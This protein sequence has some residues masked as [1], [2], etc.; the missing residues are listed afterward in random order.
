MENVPQISVDANDD[1]TTE[2]ASSIETTQSHTY[3]TQSNIVVPLQSRD[4]SFT[5]S[6]LNFNDYTTD[7]DVHAGFNEYNHDA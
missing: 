5:S 4:L 2:Q 6:V 7:L 3:G 1:Q